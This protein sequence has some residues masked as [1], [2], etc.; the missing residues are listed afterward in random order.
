MDN[1]EDR[2][3][4]LGIAI[5]ALT[6]IQDSDETDLAEYA[7]FCKT[8]TKEALRDMKEILLSKNQPS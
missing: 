7:E 6:K 3:K 8:T 5:P 1:D 4:M 2:I